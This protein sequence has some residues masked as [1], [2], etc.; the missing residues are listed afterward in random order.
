MRA[1]LAVLLIWPLG[2]GHADT[3]VAVTAIPSQTILTPAHLGV[4][5]IDV[6]GAI[7]DPARVIGLETRVNLYPNRPIRAQDVGAP[8]VVK[9]NQIV[10]LVYAQAGLNIQIDARALA[11]GGIGDRL[12]VMNLAS[13]TVVWGIVEAP[14]RV[15]V[16]DE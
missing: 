12:R 14:G 6:T 8:R 9:R 11:A 10:T 1:V 16:K 5:D 15:R 4:L 7:T 2:A 3:V 13:K